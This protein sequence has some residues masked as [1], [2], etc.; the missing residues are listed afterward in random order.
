MTEASDPQS[1]MFTREEIA[2]C[3]ERIDSFAD[4]KVRMLVDSCRVT[5]VRDPYLVSGGN[6]STKIIK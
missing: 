1:P 5:W 6:C 3:A 4:A 2:D